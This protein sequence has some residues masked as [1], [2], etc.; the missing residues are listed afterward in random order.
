MSLSLASL[1]RLGKHTGLEQQ[2][3]QLAGPRRCDGD[4]VLCRRYKTCDG[5]AARSRWR[6]SYETGLGGL[7]ESGWIEATT[8]GSIRPDGSFKPTR[9]T[10]QR[11]CSP[12]VD[13]AQSDSPWW[14]SLC[15]SGISQACDLP[16]RPWGRWGWDDARVRGSLR[17]LQVVF[18][19]A[20]RVPSGGLGFPI[21]FFGAWLG[22]VPGSVKST[23]KSKGAI[24]PAMI[25]PDPV[26]VVQGKKVSESS[27]V[28]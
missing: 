18:C 28:H 16:T 24:S 27:V 9:A 8:A 15:T 10:R 23:D 1:K 11:S 20:I 3:C 21:L 14:S 19:V 5:A 4:E 17:V 22:A 13:E 26:S 7:S 2:P 25:P 6:D 12:A